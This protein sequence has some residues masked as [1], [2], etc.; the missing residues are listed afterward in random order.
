M[1]QQATEGTRE[2]LNVAQVAQNGEDILFSYR[3]SKQ[4]V[5]RKFEGFPMAHQ[6]WQDQFAD[7]ETSLYPILPAPSYKPEIKCII[8]HEVDLFDW[9]N[10]HDGHCRLSTKLQAAWALLLAQYANSEDIV[11]GTNVV[12]QRWS[13]DRPGNDSGFQ[14]SCNDVMPLRVP[15][16]WHSDLVEWLRKIQVRLEAIEDVQSW[17]GLD[18]IRSCSPKAE[19]ACDFRTVLLTRDMQ[20]EEQEVKFLRR[21]FFRGRT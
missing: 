12:S 3:L 4:F 5:V 15:V 8:E 1:H 2:A 18:R 19:E 9:S 14:N 21:F 20:S 13:L 17:G 11:F 7:L 10:V 6:F 16:H